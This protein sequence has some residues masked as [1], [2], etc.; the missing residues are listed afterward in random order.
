MS[1]SF[2][3]YSAG[4]K[5]FQTG[6]ASSVAVHRREPVHPTHIE[7]LFWRFGLLG[8]CV[9]LFVLFARHR[10]RTFPVFTLLIGANIVRSVTL[11]TVHLHAGRNPYLGTYFSFAL[12]DFSLQIGVAYEIASHV[13]RPTGVWAP[14]T[15]TGTL[16]LAV[17]LSAIA[18]GIASLPAPPERRLLKGWTAE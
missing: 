17:V 13:F 5:S 8:H 9:L 10:A 14:D 16:V 12:L 4:I 1:E 3:T 7:I 15:R 18:L 2:S 6:N 11:Y